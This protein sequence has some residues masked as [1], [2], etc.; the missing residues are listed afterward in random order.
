MDGMAKTFEET[1]KTSGDRPL[2][3]VVDNFAIGETRRPLD[4]DKDIGRPAVQLRQVFEIDVH[5]TERGLIKTTRPLRRLFFRQTRQAMALQ[6][7]VD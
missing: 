3:A 2:P 6:A 5:I 1:L 7:S 4:G